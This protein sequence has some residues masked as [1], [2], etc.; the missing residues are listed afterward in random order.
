MKE[1]LAATLT[2][3]TLSDSSGNYDTI[4][5][6][7]VNEAE[8]IPRPTSMPTSL[9]TV[10]PTYGPSPLYVTKEIVGGTLAG[11]LVLLILYLAYGNYS[12][13]LENN[14][15]M[16]K[17]RSD[18]EILQKKIKENG[19]GII[20]LDDEDSSDVE[21][22]WKDVQSNEGEGGVE[23]GQGMTGDAEDLTVDRVYQ[24]EKDSVKLSQTN[25]LNERRKGKGKGKG[26]P[27]KGNH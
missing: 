26:N 12:Y 7:Y 14:A 9:P 13:T 5:S 23:E 22:M 4:T 25:P 1:V 16:E 24:N 3:L 10:S 17:Y 15:R 21:N 18:F 8:I 6:T 27:K 2:V 19:G 11:I 20:T